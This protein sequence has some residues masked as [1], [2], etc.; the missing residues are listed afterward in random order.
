MSKKRALTGP[1][2]LT[3]TRM[4]L[5]ILFFIFILLPYTWAKITALILFIVAA[6]SDSVDGKWARKSKLVTDFGAFLDPLADK[7]LVNLA[8]LA[9]VNIGVVPVWIFAIILIRDFAI[10]GIR[11]AAARNGV[12]I[13]ASVYGKSKTVIQMIALIILILNTIAGNSALSVVGNIALCV[14]VI[15][16]I[17]SGIDY[18]IK[19]WRL[20]I[21]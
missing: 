11:M 5:A 3:M 4:F 20:L 16:T 15:A 21:K 19:G 18:L 7:T 10:D 12:T 17:V 6:I 1:T 9:L 14:A 13:S 2:I 8:F